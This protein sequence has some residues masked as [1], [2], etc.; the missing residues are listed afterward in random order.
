DGLSGRPLGT[1]IPGRVLPAVAALSLLGAVGLGVLGSV[2]VS[3]WLLAFVAFGAFIV[4]A[5]NLELFGGRFHSDLWFALAW[6]A[7]PALTASFAQQQSIGVPA[8]LAAAACML[9]S[10]AQRTL[11]TPV[12]ELR[13]RVAGVSG[14]IRYGDGSVR[15]ID[16]SV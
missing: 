8:V 2:E 10:A 11:S 12:R 1:L 13:R 15:T 9:L 14:E 4:L 6:G 7:F 5:Y 16:E 3:G